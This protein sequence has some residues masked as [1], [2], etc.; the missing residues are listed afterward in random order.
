MSVVPFDFM[1]TCTVLSGGS[2]DISDFALQ[3][4]EATVTVFVYLH[5]RNEM[6]RESD[7]RDVKVR[8]AGETPFNYPRL[9][10]LELGGMT[11]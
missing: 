6:V 11:L 10:V 3:E 8:G 9:I 4:L 2:W 5:G 7:A 1:R